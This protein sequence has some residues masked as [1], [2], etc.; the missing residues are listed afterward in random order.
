MKFFIQQRVQKLQHSSLAINIKEINNA[1]NILFSVFSRYGDGL[2]SF[3]IIKEFIVKY[4][5]KQYIILT[6]KQQFPY[7]RT[8]LEALNNV[9]IK[10][11]NKRNPFSFFK[12]IYFLKHKSIDIGFNPWGHGKDSEYFVTFAKRFFF[13]KKFDNFPKTHNLY[14]RVRK[15]FLLETMKEKILHSFPVHN[16]KNIVLAPISTD[17]TKNLSLEQITYLIKFLKTNIP[18]ANITVA[19]P[20]TFK[21]IPTN[22]EKFIFGKST[23]KSYQYLQLLRSCDLF[24]GVDSGPLH[25]A[26]ALNIDSIGI[27]GPT[28]PA[29]ILDNK[30][31]IIVLRDP[32]LH[33][34]FC[35]VN[36]CEYPICINN[37]LFEQINDTHKNTLDQKVIL[38]TKVCLMKEK[39]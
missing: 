39:N 21:N 20:K 14:D 19:L 16:K 22:A 38:E 5:D 7:A 15:Y 36:N 26:L 8:I 4:P 25:L 12:T 9:M 17:I 6:S 35:F 33:N 18:M 13:Y 24:I 11:V 27:F 10:K 1:N 28:S 30:Q 32:N 37:T 34:H 31:K 3:V 29:T 23:E 2:I